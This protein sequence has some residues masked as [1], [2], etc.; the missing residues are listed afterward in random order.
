MANLLARAFHG[1]NQVR[2][3]LA[4][5]FG[6]SFREPITKEYPQIV[7]DITTNFR[8]RLALT[9]NPETGDHLCI[10][11]RQCERVCP[12]KCIEITSAKSAETGKLE[13]IDFKIDHGL[14]MFCGLCTE[15][16]PTYCIINTNDFELSEYAREDLIYDLKKLTLSQDESAF[17]FERKE[18]PLPKP[19]PA[20][21]APAAG[22]A[23]AAKPAAA[24][25]AAAK[26]EAPKAEEKKEEPKAEAPRAEEKKEEKKEEPKAEAPKAEEK[27]EE[28]KE[29]PK[30]DSPAAE[31]KKD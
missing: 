7:P 3:G 20:K 15:V 31:E 16:C 1:L 28:K 29:E 13:L 17:Y 10:S 11:C 26:A 4:T 9:V 25:P 2:R 5:V 27:K 24:A 22:A 30:A 19:K 23:P 21:A 18:M 6:H 8:G 12:D 14:C